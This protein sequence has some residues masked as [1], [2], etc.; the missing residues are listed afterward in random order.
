MSQENVHLVIELDRIKRN[1]F[2]RVDN[3]E[4][5]N[6]INIRPDIIEKLTLF[7]FDINEIILANREY[8]FKE[9]EEA[10]FIMMKD[11]ETQMYNHKFMG[12]KIEED[13]NDN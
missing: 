1:S 8:R 6:K 13:K 12:K 11:P 9:I 4:S 5:V 2:C 7:G 3:Q 10:C